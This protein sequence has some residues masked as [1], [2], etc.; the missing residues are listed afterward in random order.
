M[1]P[2]SGAM[3]D[4]IGTLAASLAMDEVK[5]KKRKRKRNEGESICLG[6]IFTRRCE[7]WMDGKAESGFYKRKFGQ[8]SNLL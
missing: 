7:S 6:G 4:S 3:L 5:I 1:A 8:D 2:F